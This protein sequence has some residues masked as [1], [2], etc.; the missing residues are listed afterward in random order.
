[1]PSSSDSSV[2]HTRLS[3]LVVGGGIAGLTA[4]LALRHQGHTVRVLES[5]SWLRET[6]AAVILANNASIALLSL[7]LDPERDI[8]AARFQNALD[9]YLKEGE[10]PV[11]GEGGSG[12]QLPWVE[13]ARTRFEGRYFMAHRVDLHQALVEKCVDP[14][15][16]L[17]AND[18][19]ATAEAETAT[20]GPPVEVIRAERVVGWERAASHGTVR[21]HDG[22]E[23]QADLVVAA[24][25]IHSLA[26][27]EVVGREVAVVPS[28]VSTTRFM[29]DTTEI[30]EDPVT[31]P[32]MDDGDGCLVFYYTPSRKSVLMRYPCHRYVLPPPLFS[33]LNRTICGSSQ[34]N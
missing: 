34:R 26:H 7:G 4:A 31:A 18:A 13:M 25:G 10:V 30:L 23:F 8:K 9:Y 1:M 29:L 22:Q 2:H 11:F 27:V 6:G 32:I 19:A 14:H 17:N 24:D 3:I 16:N 21:L 28:G 15:L 33:S 12:V 20:S 5:S